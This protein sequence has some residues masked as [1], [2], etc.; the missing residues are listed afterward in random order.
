MAVNSETPH[1][2][3]RIPAI[4]LGSLVAVILLSTLL[5]RVSVNGQIDLPALLGTKNNGELIKPPRPISELPL[6]EENGSVFDFSKQQKQWSI[7]IPVTAHCDAQCQQNLYLTRQIHTAL[8]KDS[9]R[10]RRYL[11]A[12]QWPLDAEFEKVLEAHPKLQ[13]LKADAGV[14]DQYFAQSQLQPVR[15]QQY[16]IIDP[17]GWFMMYYGPHHDGKVVI[18]DLKFL[19]TNSHEH[20]DVN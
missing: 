17:A 5:F 8:G 4:I 3:R 1:N 2:S 10:V 20:E 6:Q 9:D 16:L 12:T 13:I 19:L 11:I 15:D 7:A 14:F 18:K